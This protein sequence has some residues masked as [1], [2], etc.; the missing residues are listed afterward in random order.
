MLILFSDERWLE[1]LDSKIA[2]LVNR[3]GV[4][5]REYSGKSYDEY[6]MINLSAMGI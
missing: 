1:W 6:V 2:L 4:D 5:P 3:S